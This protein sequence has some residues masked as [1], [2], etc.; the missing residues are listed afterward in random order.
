MSRQVLP[1]CLVFRNLISWAWAYDGDFP[2]WSNENEAAHDQSPTPIRLYKS[3]IRVS[4]IGFQPK[5]V[6][7]C[8]K[9]G[10]ADGI[11]DLRGCG[12]VIEFDA[13]LHGR[14]HMSNGGT[15]GIGQ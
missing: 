1:S 10:I 8:P 9:R 6:L 11:A 12:R 3:G 7:W 13:V 5:G 15:G 14:L 2:I 4:S